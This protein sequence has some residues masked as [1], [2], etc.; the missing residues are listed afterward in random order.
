MAPP[1]KKYPGYASGSVPAAPPPAPNGGRSPAEVMKDWQPS[2][3]VEGGPVGQ[4]VEPEM[5]PGVADQILATLRNVEPFKTVIDK[6]LTNTRGA[7]AALQ[8]GQAPLP[9]ASAKAPAVLDPTVQALRNGSTAA[10]PNQ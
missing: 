8:G 7:G 10:I 1:K 2:P 9:P 6:I 5:G 3:E 4:P